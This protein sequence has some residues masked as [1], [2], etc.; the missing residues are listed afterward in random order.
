MEKKNGLKMIKLYF[1]YTLVVLF[2]LVINAAEQDSNELELSTIADLSHVALKNDNWH[3]VLPIPGNNEH[4]FI[5]TST[6]NVYQINQHDIS[7]SPFFE[8]KSALNTT[9]NI[10]LTAITLDPNFNYRERDGYH[11]FYTAHTEQSK[12]TKSKLSPKH[13]ELNPSYDAVIMRWQ[14]TY[15]VNQRPELNKQREVMRIA[16]NHE[17]E[18][19]QQLSF[20]PYIEPWHN[21]FGLLF[22]ALAKS[23]NLANE[24]LYAGTILRIRPKAYGARSYTTPVNNPFSKQDDILNEIVFIA[25]QEIIH[26]NWMKKG[27]YNF[28]IQLNHQNSHLLVKAKIGDD[29]RKSMPAAQIKQRLASVNSPSKTFLYHGRELKNLWGKVLHLQTTADSWQLQASPLFPELSNDESYEH[30]P[31]N[32][33]RYSMS[34]QAKFSLHQR[35]D[36]E[37]LLL[38]H[39]KQRLYSIKQP[40]IV[41]NK[42]MVD[43]VPITKTNNSS[44]FTFIIFTL[45][46]L[47]SYFY[48]LRKRTNK[49]QHLLHEQWAN[50]DIDL[51]KK[52]LKL[53]KRHDKNAEKVIE[54]SALT[55]SELLLNDKVISTID[56]NSIQ[57][58]SNELEAQVLTIF[59]KENQ[60]KMIDEKQ[61]RIQLCLTDK[62]KKS[63]LFCLYFRVGNMRH[64]KL[65]YSTVINKVIDWQWLFSQYI[66]PM[67]TSKRK[68]K[69]KIKPKNQAD[70]STT[71]VKKVSPDVC[72]KTSDQST[73][74]T[75]T[76]DTSHSPSDT[77]AQDSSHS[78]N[79]DTIDVD[80]RLVAALDKL[81]M[82][83]KQGYLDESEFNMAKT[84]IL[85]D[86]ANET[87][88]L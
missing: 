48:Y 52:S 8:L 51:E 10:T 26:F 25:G 53:Y 65:K 28:L 64:T 9:E 79:D 74:G 24:A 63:Y 38:E 70:S 60:L 59:A 40:E 42:V 22:I 34:K 30:S 77:F 78:I 68:I 58:F 50:F 3:T 85:K 83:K 55:R 71:A 32:L 39:N 6:G 49:Q 37:L 7:P 80:T 17:Q 19:I 56:V 1:I 54:I 73:S 43:D 16:I 11:T 69:V 27:N 67:T 36:G 2:S 15:A 87:S 35:H 18:H 20:N 57:S 75:K 45:V 46:I 66:N 82:M 31:H 62:Q 61:R 4:Y 84:K 21:D 41:L 23:E 14:L 88:N 29:W 72:D 44:A 33:G 81:V 12:K 47:M 86:L 76:S 5:A 13:S